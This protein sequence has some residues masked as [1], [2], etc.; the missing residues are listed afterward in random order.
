MTVKVIAGQGFDYFS[1]HQ[2][3]TLVCLNPLRT[4]E[5]LVHGEIKTYWKPTTTG[6]IL[7]VNHEFC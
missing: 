5:C 3:T 7:P 1:V 2:S 4:A 6:F